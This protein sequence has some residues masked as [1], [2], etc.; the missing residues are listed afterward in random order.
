[1]NTPRAADAKAMVQHARRTAAEFEFDHGYP[2]PVAFL[3][4]KLADE[5]QVNLI[6]FADT[7]CDHTRVPHVCLRYTPNMH[8]SGARLSSQCLARKFG[9]VRILCKASHYTAPRAQS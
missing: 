7:R 1:M 8:T 3:A 6:N 9:A 4:K 5:N 2:I